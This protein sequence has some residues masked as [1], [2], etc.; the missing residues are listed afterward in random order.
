MQEELQCAQSEK[1]L[2]EHR[3][4]VHQQA[5][6]EVREA[7]QKQLDRE[8]RAICEKYEG[9]ISSYD[10]RI[11][12]INDMHARQCEQLCQEVVDANQEVMRL[13]NG[14]L[15]V[16]RP[17]QLSGHGNC[18]VQRDMVATP[19]THTLRSRSMRILIPVFIVLIAVFWVPQWKAL[20]TMNGVVPEF[21]IPFRELF[22][23]P[24]SEPPHTVPV[25]DASSKKENFLARHWNKIL[26]LAIE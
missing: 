14:L 15:E 3:L 23:P 21:D 17:R 18:R 25:M 8:T 13:Q 20:E 5:S 10:R 4:A 16:S 2:L 26:E 9:I 1:E 6:S 11:L 19:S 24:V 22:R 7:F 12:E